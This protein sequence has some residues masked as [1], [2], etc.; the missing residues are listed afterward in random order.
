MP[1]VSHAYV[2]QCL[3]SSNTCLKAP[4]HPRAREAREKRGKLTA[5]DDGSLDVVAHVVENGD[6]Y[7]DL[8]ALLAVRRHFHVYIEGKDGY[9][10]EGRGQHAEAVGRAH[11]EGGHHPV[12]R[13][14]GHIDV[15]DKAAVGPDV[16]VS[17][18]PHVLILAL[19]AV[20]APLSEEGD[21]RGVAL[22]DFPFFRVAR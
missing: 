8:F 9:V 13:R 7:A 17:P 1:S 19:D 20:E 11:A 21:V 6:A 2:S 12:H 4:A 18:Q 15:E 14:L 22:W 5:K 16:H 3:L 10:L